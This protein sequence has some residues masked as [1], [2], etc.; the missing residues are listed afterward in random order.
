MDLLGIPYAEQLPAVQWKRRN[1]AGLEPE[2]RQHLV[3]SLLKALEIEGWRASAP[4]GITPVKTAPSKGSCKRR[5][6]KGVIRC[7][8][9]F[10]KLL[11]IW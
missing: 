11:R 10:C 3:E 5:I 1:L 7:D 6:C 2:K 8:Q 4:T 9:D